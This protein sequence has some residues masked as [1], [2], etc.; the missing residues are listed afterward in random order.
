MRKTS[1]GITLMLLLAGMLT[2]TF[3]IQPAKAWTGTVYIRADGSVDPSTAP[4]Q[5]DGDLYTIIGNIT[6]D[7]HGIM[8][9]RDNLTLDGAGYTVQGTLALNSQGIGLSRRSNVTVKNMKIKSFFNGI[10]LSPTSSNNSIVRNYITNNHIGIYFGIYSDYNSIIES[11]LINNDIG[12]DI[13]ISS[14]NTFYH[15]GIINN[16]DQV[17]I[18]TSGSPNIWDNGYPSGGNYWSDY[19]GE[20]LHSGAYQNKTNSDGIGDAPY[21]INCCNRDRYTLMKPYGG[22]V[23][24]GIDSFAVSKTLVGQGY[25]VNVNVK[26]INYGMS[27]VTFNFTTCVNTTIINALTNFTLSSRNSATIVFSWNTSGF[28]KGNYTISA[29][30]DIVL[31]ETDISD[32][33]YATAIRVA[34]AGDLNADDIVDILDIVIVAASFGSSVGQPSYDQNADINNDGAVDI[35]DI[36][37]VAAYFGEVDP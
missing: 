6:S 29:S 32:N 27:V 5:R 7:S 37:I 36:V 22:P 14:N 16:A 10:F 23:D 15:N 2:L 1:S 18:E 31:G 28:A 3:N 19:V 8:I 17:Y 30:V 12:V 11:N 20:D 13:Y 24:I 35:F 25:N 26:I 33:T 34:M 21:I 4:I 9:E